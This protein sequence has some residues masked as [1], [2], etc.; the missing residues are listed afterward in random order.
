M[1]MVPYMPLLTTSEITGSPYWTAVAIS[2]PCIRKQPSPANETTVPR[3][4]ENI[5]SVRRRDR[6]LASAVACS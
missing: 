6:I 2:C 4:E 3:I 5:P 1:R